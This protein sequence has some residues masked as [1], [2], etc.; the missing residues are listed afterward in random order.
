MSTL[1]TPK[2]L[3]ALLTVVLTG[4]AFAQGVVRDVQRDVNQQTRIDQGLKSGSLSVKEAST[5]EREQARI[6]RREKNDLKNGNISANEQARLTAAQNKASA[7]IHTDKTNGKVNNPNSVS[8]QRM[9]ADLARNVNQ[10]KLI[11]NGVKDGQLSNRAVS[12]LEDGQAHVG[13]TEANAASNGHV[14]KGE[15]RHIG[16]TENGQSARIHRDRAPGN[17]S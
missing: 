12:K 16:R 5:L 14:S 15:E 9:Q 6:D 11:E 7:D 10:E 13:R 1:S 2:L 4:S 8:S 17:H 3:A